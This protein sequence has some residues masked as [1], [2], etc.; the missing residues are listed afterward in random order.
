[1]CTH[2]CTIFILLTPFPATS[3]RLLVPTLPPGQGQLYPPVLWFCRR[4]RE[5]IKK[6]NMICLLVWDKDSYT[7]QYCFTGDQA[8]STGLFGG[9]HSTCV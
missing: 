4:E 9:T 3:P 6:K 1:M 2:F 5:K 7:F 8:S